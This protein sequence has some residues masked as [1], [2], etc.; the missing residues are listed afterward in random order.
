MN[1]LKRQSLLKEGLP[2]SKTWTIIEDTEQKVIQIIKINRDTLLEET[3]GFWEIVKLFIKY[4]KKNNPKYDL[5]IS[6]ILSNTEMYRDCLRFFFLELWLWNNIE[7][8]KTKQNKKNLS[9]LIED[10]EARY[11]FNTKNI[12]KI[13][14]LVYKNIYKPLWY[15]KQDIVVR[16]EMLWFLKAYHM[17]KEAFSSEK[18]KEVD[19]KWKRKRAFEH[20]KET[21]LI[22]L[23]E[24][25]QPNRIRVIAWL[26]HDSAEDIEW[27]SYELLENLFWPEIAKRVEHLTKKDWRIFLNEKER[28]IIKEIEK[29]KNK[30]Q[31][32]K[33][34][35]EN[36]K[37]KELITKWK[38]ARNFEYFWKLWKLF[39]DKDYDTLNIKFADRIH[40]LRTMSRLPKKTIVRKIIETENYFL[41]VALREKKRINNLENVKDIMKWKRHAY[42]LLIEEIE[43]LKKDPKVL[44][45]Y[46]EER[47][48]YSFQ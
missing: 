1:I 24:L 12:T 32:K 18:R 7:I 17:M 13:Y 25:P 4:K 40:N 21:S 2:L 6:D 23:T 8:K 35:K 14:D 37:Y 36:K 48:L 42:D 29:W 9:Y 16:R 19:E 45:L 34:A 22:L 20:S 46:N 28:N 11:W 30:K 10:F 44:D 27:Y 3:E 15:K 39:D 5:Q 43:K 38:K 26:L 31:L 41:E 47:S 33:L